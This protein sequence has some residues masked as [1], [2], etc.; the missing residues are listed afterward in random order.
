[1]YSDNYSLKQ[2]AR[3]YAAE[4]RHPEQEEKAKA[5]FMGEAQAITGTPW[6]EMMF[7]LARSATK[8]TV[9]VNYKRDLEF[10]LIGYKKTYRFKWQASIKYN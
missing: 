1:M 2:L 5:R 10:P 3:S 4:A 6:D 9:T 8:G 7:T